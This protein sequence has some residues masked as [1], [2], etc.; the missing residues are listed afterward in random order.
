M[1]DVQIPGDDMNPRITDDLGCIEQG[2]RFRLGYRVHDL[3]LWVEPHGLVITGRAE[4][5]YDKQLAQQIVKEL[6]ELN[7]AEN[8]IVVEA[9]PAGSGL[10]PGIGTSHQRDPQGKQKPA[11]FGPHPLHSNHRRRHSR[12]EH[13]S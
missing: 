1:T 5:Y 8:R 7:V 12:G 2:L 4:S 6:G 11:S 9:P 10:E 13:R 3:R